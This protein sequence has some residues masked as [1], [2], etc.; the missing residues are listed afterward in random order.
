MNSETWKLI[1]RKEERKRK[2]RLKGR[3]EGRMKW[4]KKERKDRLR[5]F[6]VKIGSI[7]GTNSQITEKEKEKKII[8][9][10]LFDYLL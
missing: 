1:D 8:L 4:W 7:L 6:I 5:Y 3:E 2:E 9:K 10:R